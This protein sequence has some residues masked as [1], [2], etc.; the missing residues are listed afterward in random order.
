MHIDEMI[1]VAALVTVWLIAFLFL[2]KVFAFMDFVS[3]VLE[4]KSG[5][6]VPEDEWHPPRGDDFR[7]VA[8]I[9]A[10]EDGN[11]QIKE[12]V[13]EKMP[14]RKKESTAQVKPKDNKINPE[15]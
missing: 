8:E 13:V 10:G 15:V 12:I 9:V 11:L 2:R 7:R 3:R 4:K 5:V 1:A 14:P 6:P